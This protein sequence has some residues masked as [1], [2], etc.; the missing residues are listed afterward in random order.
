M[1]HDKRQVQ[2]L[3][4]NYSDLR[5]YRPITSRLYSSILLSF[6]NIAA[7]E[8][9]SGF[10]LYG[11]LL[12]IQRA[13]GIWFGKHALYTQ[14]DRLN[15]I[16]CRPF[17]LKNVETDVAGHINVGVIHWRD[18]DDMWGGVRICWRKGERKFEGKIS[19]GLDSQS[20]VRKREARG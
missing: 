8:G 17:L 4:R 12:S 13:L 9:V 18:K 11:S 19:I 3:F 1:Y 14:E 15:I 6:H 7:L 20:H 10:H 2:A 16:D 5:L